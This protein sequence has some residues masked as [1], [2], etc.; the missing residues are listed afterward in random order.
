M[1]LESGALLTDLYQLTMLQAYFR[2]DMAGTASFE[3]FVRKLPPRRN[4]LVAAGL[5]PLLEYLETFRFPDADCAWLSGQPDFTPEFIEHLARMRFTGDVDALP[6]GTVFFGNEPVVRITAPL[7]EA[8]IVESRLINLIHLQTLVASKAA[9][10]VLAA[11]GRLLVDFGLR[12]A[13]GA[14]AG[15]LAAR[16]AWLAGFGGTSNVLA[17][18]RFG[19]PIHGTMAHSYIMAHEDEADAFRRFAES[20]PGHVTLLI[21][22]YDTLE[23]ARKAVALAPALAEQG[24]PIEAVRLD[25]GDLLTLATEVRTI[26]DHGGLTH[27]RIFASGDLDEY[28]L[29]RLLAGGAPIDGFGVGS[30]LVTSEDAPYL[31]CAY[32][33]QEYAGVPKRKRSKGKETWPGRKQVHRCYDEQGRMNGDLLATASEAADG[34]PLL[35]PV[36]RGGKRLRPPEPLSMARE[37]LRKQLECLPAELKSID[38]PAAY[39]VAISPGLRNL[40]DQMDAA[41][42]EQ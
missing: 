32:K 16:A 21:D 37:R 18:R 12:R 36:M 19:I 20:L 24:I 11:P 26:L 5:E 23:G 33:L 17:G 25:S 1:N 34:E 30:R 9:R 29:A 35:Q 13:H 38:T 14:E 27:C 8:Q 39:P 4:F 41:D 42:A 2:E 31:N 22:T 10:S 40:V 3:L 6:E 7:P 28:E 15:L